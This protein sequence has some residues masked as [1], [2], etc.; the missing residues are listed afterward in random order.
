MNFEEAQEILDKINF[1]NY[2][3][4]VYG[5]DVDNMYLQAVYLDDD[6]ITGRQE[7]QRTRKW[8][9]SKHMVPSEL[10]QTAFKCVMTSMEHR[11][12]EGFKYK[13]ERIYGPHFDC[14]ALVE[15]CR[16]KRLEYRK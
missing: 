16:A 4:L 10:V 3:F 5:M 13:G 11:A 6:I 7:E 8:L 9:L 1:Q 14:E 12:R 2:T 15:L